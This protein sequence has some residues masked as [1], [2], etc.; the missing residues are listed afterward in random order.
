MN[1]M[2]RYLLVFFMI[3]W[4]GCQQ[5]YQL[6]QAQQIAEEVRLEFAPDKRVALFRIDT[7]IGGK[8]LEFHG[9]TNLPEAKKAFFEKLKNAGISFSDSL[10]L[11][12]SSDLNGKHFGVVNVSVCNFRSEPKHSAE[13]ATQSLLGTTLR[14]WKKQGDF[15][16]VQSPDNYFGWL[17]DGGLE[18]M[19][20]DELRNWSNSMRAMV[21][22]DFTFAYEN[23]D[24]NSQKLTDLVAGDMLQIVDKHD[25]FTK[26]SLPDGRVGFV[27]RDQVLPLNEWLASRNPTAENVL[28][29]AREMMGRPYLWGGT[30]GKGIDCSG[31]TKMAFF[32]NGIQLPRDASQQVHVGEQIDADTSTLQNLQPGDLLFFGRNATPE[33]KERISHV[34]IYMGGGKIIHASDR[35]KVESLIRGDSTFVIDR[36][37]SFVRSKRILGQ[38]GKNGVIRVADSPYYQPVNDLR[39]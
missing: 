36:L 24:E 14:V 22:K 11:L 23:A 12:P 39:D 26:I 31:F 28:A 21:T 15:Y 7:I 3:G 13:L 16:L 30:S 27:F 37:A 19:T 17:D 33:N 29:S 6:K 34:A 8:R 2:C 1:V 10:A 32:L 5:N 38:E 9:E 4:L 20:A 25:N 35:V 18:L